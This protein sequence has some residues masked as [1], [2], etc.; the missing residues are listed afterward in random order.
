[1]RLAFT[2]SMA[3]FPNGVRTFTV[4]PII[5]KARRLILRALPIR[6]GCETCDP[7]WKLEIQRP[8]NAAPRFA[9]ANAPRCRRLFLNDYCGFVAC[10]ALPLANCSKC[11]KHAPM[12]V[13]SKLQ[14][15][16]KVMSLGNA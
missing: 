7:R 9:R 3:M 15:G 1:M 6:Q 16:A 12:T 2:I 5:E 10:V 8:P 11:W 13:G 4:L 14:L